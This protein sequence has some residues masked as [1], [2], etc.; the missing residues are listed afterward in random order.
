MIHNE[1]WA[2]IGMKKGLLCD[3]C[4]RKRLNRPLRVSD[5]TNC[6]FNDVWFVLAALCNV[7]WFGDEKQ[8]QFVSAAKLF[9]APTDIIP[10][11]D[12]EP[13][14]TRYDKATEANNEPSSKAHPL[15]DG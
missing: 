11:M 13:S 3:V 1:L 5:L 7:K 12:D 6:P 8:K 4:L 14:S 10:G 9:V 15:T 2:T